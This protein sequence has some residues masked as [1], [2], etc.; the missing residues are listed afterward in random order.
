[1]A[2]KKWDTAALI[3]GIRKYNNILNN[4]GMMK[5]SKLTPFQIK[6]LNEILKGSKIS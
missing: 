5:D 1:M 6:Q 3:Q 2:S 4:I